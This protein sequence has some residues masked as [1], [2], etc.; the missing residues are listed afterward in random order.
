MTTGG[1]ALS[2]TTGSDALV[3]SSAFVTWT[4]DIGGESAGCCSVGEPFERSAASFSRS[5]G[6]Q[7]GVSSLTDCARTYIARGWTP[8]ALGSDSEN[9]PKR[10]LAKAWET[11]TP[12]DP[13]TR[14]Q[15]W[16]RAIGVGVLCGP[17]SNNLAV[18]DLDDVDFAQAVFAK[19]VRG[20]QPFRWVWTGRNRGHLYLKELKASDGKF[21]RATW[22]GREIRGEVR[23][24]GQQVAAPCTPGYTL[25]R[26]CEPQEV[27]DAHK[28]LAGV[29]LAMGAIPIVDRDHGAAGYP[30]PW[31][32]Q[33]NDG[34]RNNGTFVEACHMA[35]AR[36]PIDKAIEIIEY[37]AGHDH[38][39]DA[40]KL[41]FHEIRA[42]V[43]SAYKKA[44]PREVTGRFAGTVPE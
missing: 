40:A 14:Q 20:H 22:G 1:S 17:A 10:P 27:E 19:L 35:S 34:E 39:S 37:R 42:T 30:K 11:L 28:A 4:S 18:L 25:A 16:K 29:L 24:R 38:K 41:G 12:T 36:M 8:I 7:L 26:E 3:L 33:L 13:R 43:E 32:A 9:R 23:C 44:W 15:G 21:W 31:L 6:G 2:K 5:T